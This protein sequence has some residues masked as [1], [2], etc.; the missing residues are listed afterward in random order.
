LLSEKE[1]A[2]ADNEKKCEEAK[3]ALESAREQRRECQRLK[4]RCSMV[5]IYAKK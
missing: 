1:R 5:I 2:Q 3:K 4:V